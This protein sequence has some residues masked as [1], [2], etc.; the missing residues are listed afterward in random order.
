M[1]ADDGS[2]VQ[3]SLQ[4]HPAVV[5]AQGFYGLF[6]GVIQQSGIFH[7]DSGQNPAGCTLVNLT[8][9]HGHPDLYRVPVLTPK[10]N[11]QNGESIDPEPGDQVVVAFLNG[12]LCQPVV[13]GFLPPPG[14]TLQ[15]VSS[16]APLHHTHWQGTDIKLEKDG[17]RRVHVAKDDLLNV[18]ENQTETIHGARSI[19][20]DLTDT[21]EV[22]GDQTETMHGNR[23]QTVNIDDTLT[24]HQNRTATVDDN[25]TLT[26][27]GSRTATI[28]VNDTLTVTGNRQADIDGTD[29]L[30][31]AGDQTE[32]IHGS[33]QV[34][35]GVN[36]TLEVTGTG[37][38]IIHGA[39]TVHI[40]STANITVDGNTTITTP[41][42][43]VVASSKIRLQS[44]LVECT[45]NITAT[46]TITAG[47]NIKST[48]GEVGDKI[49]NMSGDRT[50]Y[51]GH[52]HLETGAITFGPN[53]QQ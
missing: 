32:T 23:T 40:Y 49:R 14:N 28:D 47:G 19:T 52:Q 50:I 53:N 27:H 26:V 5:R 18:V 22:T 13:I 21:L 17:I 6:L 25:D 12:N 7:S 43:T 15:P 31:V 2:R 37:T 8:L 38:I 35:I 44:P 34:N 3:G 36:D 29:T 1:F 16:D 41:Q 42:A 39:A 20:V 9:L 33:R 48:N 10:A 4:V 45:G 11:R 46:G 24:V 30:D 51:N